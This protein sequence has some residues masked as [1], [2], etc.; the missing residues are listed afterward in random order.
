M[1][2]PVPHHSMTRRHAVN[3]KH[4]RLKTEGNPDIANSWRLLVNHTPCNWSERFLDGESWQFISM[5]AP[6]LQCGTH[7]IIV[8]CVFGGEN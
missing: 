4:L 2:Q 7:E 6:A 8:G 3:N 5:S 1:I